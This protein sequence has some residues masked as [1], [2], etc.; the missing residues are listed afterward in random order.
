M[1]LM[2]FVF[3]FRFLFKQYCAEGL[4]RSMVRRS[5]KGYLPDKVRLNNRVKGIQGAD[6]MQRLEPKWKIFLEEVQQIKTS[7]F[8]QF[9]NIETIERAVS[10]I[11]NKPSPESIMTSDFKMLTWSLIMYRFLQKHF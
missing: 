3:A 9:F 5:L 11:G 10:N 7:N 6:T 8:Q 1:I 2:L 4:D